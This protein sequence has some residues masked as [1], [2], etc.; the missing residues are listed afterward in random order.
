MHYEARVRAQGR[1]IKKALPQW[2][3]HELKR[4]ITSQAEADRMGSMYRVHLERMAKEKNI[5]LRQLRTLSRGR[6]SALA[7]ITEP[8]AADA[9]GLR[10]PR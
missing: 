4:P 7:G 6:A 1:A 9:D 3:A 8:G 2:I 10:L 5:K